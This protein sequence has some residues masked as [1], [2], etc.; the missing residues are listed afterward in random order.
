MKYLQHLF[1]AQSMIAVIQ[2]HRFTRTAAA[3]TGQ[4]S[5]KDLLNQNEVVSV[6]PYETGVMTTPASALVLDAQ[7][8]SA[9]TSWRF[10]IHHPGTDTKLWFDMGIS[11]NLSSYPESVQAVHEHFKPAPAARS[12]AQDTE[13]AGFKPS[14]VKYVIAS[15]AHWDHVRPLPVEFNNTTMIC[16]PGTIE[17]YG[18]AYPTEPESVF[19][20]R[21]WDSNLRTFPLEELPPTTDEAWFELGPFPHALDFFN[22]GSVFLI[23]APGHLQGNLALLTRVNGT[24]GTRKWLFL[25]GDCAACNIFTYWPEAPFGLMP[26]GTMDHATLHEN[27]DEA[28]STIRLISE[29][30]KD[31]GQDFLVWYAHSEMLEG[32]WEVVNGTNTV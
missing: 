23:N 5:L 27:E 7:S 32:F 12:L 8:T 20:G 26:A 18:P 10:F 28:R 1:I 2:G 31:V 6:I 14:D 13:D 29:C 19:D 9:G 16:G 25:G 30:K 11:S 4:G 17:T 3:I 22:D 24:D 21:I 15:H